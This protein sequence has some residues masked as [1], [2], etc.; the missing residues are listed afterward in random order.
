MPQLPSGSWRDASGWII[1]S[2]LLGLDTY[3]N[4][5]RAPSL[6]IIIRKATHDFSQFL[7][8]HESNVMILVN[9]ISTFA[10]FLE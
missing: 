6:R 3:G 4:D 2:V 5:W 1:Y 10:R 9:Q 8:E 7:N